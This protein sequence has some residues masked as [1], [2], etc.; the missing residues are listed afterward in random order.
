MQRIGSDKQEYHSIEEID[1]SL[2]LWFVPEERG[3]FQP[4]PFVESPNDEVKSI[5]SLK[6]SGTFV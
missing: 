3:A 4:Q 5:E 6:I 1:W 2:A